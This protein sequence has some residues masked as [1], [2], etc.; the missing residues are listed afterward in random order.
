MVLQVAWT[1]PQGDGSTISGV[2]SI[3]DQPQMDQFRKEY[4]SLVGND[5]FAEGGYEVPNVNA[6]TGGAAS[7]S[8]SSGTA[9]ATTSAT[10]SDVVEPTNTATSSTSSGGKHG[11]STGAIAGIA[12]GCGIVGILVIGAIIFLLFRRGKRKNNIQQGGY[13][14]Q[15]SENNFISD[16]ETHSRVIETGAPGGAYQQQVPLNGHQHDQ[17]DTYHP[18]QDTPLAQGAVHD[19]HSTGSPIESHGGASQSRGNVAHLVEDG[20]TEDDIRRLEREERELDEEIE[21]AGRR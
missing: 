5:Q 9:S 10:A 21:R 20:M 6:Q 4:A 15:Q 18:Y 7:T 3:G 11:L 8:A 19:T 14:A 16:K 17:N 2:F 1:D 13:S 12:V